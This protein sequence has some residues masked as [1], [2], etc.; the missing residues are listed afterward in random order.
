MQASCSVSWGV[1]ISGRAAF[2]DVGDVAIGAVNIDDGEHIV[3]QLPGGTHE[4]LPSQI[5]LLAWAFA[6]KHHI[7]IPL[8]YAEDHIVSGFTQRAG[9]ASIAFF[10]QLLPAQHYGFRLP[11]LPLRRRIWARRRARRMELMAR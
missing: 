9:S 11:F 7:R 6:H 1:P 5:L 3:Q 4:G 2:D 8:P 10:F